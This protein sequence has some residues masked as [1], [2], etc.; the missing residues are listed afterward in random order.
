MAQQKIERKGENVIDLGKVISV[1]I[2]KLGEEVIDT[3]VTEGSTVN[4]VLD[5]EG[6]SI[7]GRDVRVN[8][9]LLGRERPLEEGDVITIIPNI[10]GAK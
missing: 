9:E 7:E 1:K 3:I 5:Q 8:N 6:V 2:A 10:A 4:Q